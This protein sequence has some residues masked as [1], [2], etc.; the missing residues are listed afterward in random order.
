M[1]L[2]YTAFRVYSYNSIY[3]TTKNYI[4][5]FAR[6]SLLVIFE[7]IF[8]KRIFDMCLGRSKTRIQQAYHHAMCCLLVSRNKLKLY[9]RYVVA[10]VQPYFKDDISL[11]LKFNQ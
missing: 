3:H 9:V 5:H 8:Q 10:N 2:E 4:L 11:L 6:N 1:Q 7:E